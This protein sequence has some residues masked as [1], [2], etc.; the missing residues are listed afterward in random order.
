MKNKTFLNECFFQDFGIVNLTIKNNNFTF[1]F[2]KNRLFP[3]GQINDRKP[4]HSENY[5]F[6]FQMFHEKTVFIRPAMN[7]FLVHFTYNT[8]NI[9]VFC[10]FIHQPIDTA[11]NLYIVF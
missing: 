10:I 5:R 1:I 11:H 3:R 8:L 9:C 6:I 2:G 4:S 7:D